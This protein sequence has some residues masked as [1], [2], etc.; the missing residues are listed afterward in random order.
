[1]KNLLLSL[2]T[3]CI[4]L[5]CTHLLG[6]AETVDVQKATK[7]NGN[8]LEQASDADN[9]VNSVFEE[10]TESELEELG[11]SEE[12]KSRLTQ[13]LR[14]A[15]ENLPMDTEKGGEE[16]AAESD[17]NNDALEPFERAKEDIAKIVKQYREDAKEHLRKQLR[18]NFAKGERALREFY[19][20]DATKDEIIEEIIKEWE[21]AFNE[22]A[23][24]PMDVKIGIAFQCLEELI[25]EL[26][27]I[28]TTWQTTEK[29]LSSSSSLL[30]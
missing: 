11:V 25:P 3:V 21:E 18:N 15:P 9:E 29:K 23:K 17:A 16:T 10:A 22:A 28:S 1:M 14:E 12:M 27:G 6:E 13:R 24:I 19:G 20:K 26:V 5:Y 8:N 4:A 7:E 2:A 30:L